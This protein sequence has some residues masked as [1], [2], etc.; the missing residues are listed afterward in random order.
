VIN[1]LKKIKGVKTYVPDGAFYLMVELPVKDAEDFSRFLLEDFR[2]DN[3][4]V[5]L[6]TVKGFY[7]TENKGVNEIRIAYV[8]N[9]AELKKAIDIIGKGLEAYTG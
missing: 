5:M 6:A 3:T 4:T 7:L 1:N 2:I 9:S 8:V